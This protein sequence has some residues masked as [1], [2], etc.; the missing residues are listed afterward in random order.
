MFTQNSQR[1]SCYCRP[2]AALIA[3][4]NARHDRIMGHAGAF[5]GPSELSAVD[6]Y[7]ALEEVG[8]K[9]TDH[10]AKFGV[11][12]K[13]LLRKKSLPHQKLSLVCQKSWSPKVHV[14][15]LLRWEGFRRLEVIIL[16]QDL[17]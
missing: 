13:E 1:I 8:V 16:L 2:I 17:L 9:M 11:I 15:I 12:M 3:G 5:P 6:K 7:R 14:L 4:T 10:P